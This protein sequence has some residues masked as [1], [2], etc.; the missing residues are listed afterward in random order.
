MS[1]TVITGYR[2]LRLLA[3][4]SLGF[5]LVAITV[6][7]LPFN[8]EGAGMQINRTTW[9]NVES[10]TAAIVANIPTLYTLRK[11]LPDRSTTLKKLNG[12]LIG[13]WMEA[14]EKSPDGAA[15][16]AGS[17][18]PTEDENSPKK[19]ILAK[20]SVEIQERRKAMFIPP[21][22]GKEDEVSE[23]WD[24]RARIRG[25]KMELMDDAEWQRERQKDRHTAKATAIIAATNFRLGP[26]IARA[27]GGTGLDVT[28]TSE[29]CL[30][31]SRLAWQRPSVT[32]RMS[33]ALTDTKAC[34]NVPEARGGQDDGGRRAEKKGV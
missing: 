9:A 26:R 30:L 12:G 23:G 27:A 5:F 20:K 24:R 8:V 7:R 6:I 1:P 28:V 15:S 16:D 10:F 19:H 18:Q 4:F 2:K 29:S 32:D 31:A 14:G 21:L 33:S 11:K 13:G 3:L 25:G 34:L 22:P 17:L